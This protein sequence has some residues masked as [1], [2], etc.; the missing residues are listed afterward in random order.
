MTDDAGRLHK[1]GDASDRQ[2]IATVGVDSYSLDNPYLIQIASIFSDQVESCDATFTEALQSNFRIAST[3]TTPGDPYKWINIGETK[4]V[5]RRYKL[6]PDKLARNW[7]CT[8]DIA[9]HT[10]N[11]TT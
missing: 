10:L 9:Q 7:G 2:F 8:L 5:Q 1:P 6:T 4:T 3:A 11:V